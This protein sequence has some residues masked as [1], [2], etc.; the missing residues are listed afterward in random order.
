[1]RRGAKA[2]RDTLRDLV[3]RSPVVEDPV[4]VLV[5]AFVGDSDEQAPAV[6]AKATAG[7]GATNAR[8]PPCPVAPSSRRET[9]KIQL[10]SNFRDGNFGT[11]SRTLARRSMTM[12]M[13]GHDRRAAMLTPPDPADGPADV[14]I[15]TDAGNEIDD[16]FALAWAFLRPDRLRVLA[17]TACPF[18]YDV[19]RELAGA[20][21]AELDKHAH[22][23]GMGTRQISDF[24]KLGPAEGVGRAQDEI[25]RVLEVLGEPAGLA[26]PMGAD[27]YL[28]GPATPVASDA[29]DA[30]IE[31]AR[32]DRQRPLQVLAIGCATNIAS[33]L[34]L[35]PDIADRIVVSWTSAY[36]TF[37]PYP[38][39][40]YNLAQDLHAARVLF[41]S[42]VPLVYLPGYYVGEELRVTLPEID[43]HVAGR[44]PIGDDLAT[45]FRE[46][47]GAAR[48]PGW[49]KVLWDLINVAWVVEPA[50]LAT[51]L[52]TAPI[53]GDDLRWR[54]GG[55]NRH[56]IREATDIDRDSILSDLYARLAE[57]ALAPT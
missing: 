31:L 27:R 38:N 42:G 29:A 44:G 16:Q 46:W 17:V 56:Q 5:D 48:R 34:L 22:A 8:S 43:A 35:A 13:I 47:A 25:V 39:A 21:T 26:V 15:D 10:R 54:T 1:M 2:R 40:S 30:L 18:G 50:W 45:I 41:D 51:N 32:Q 20:G 12:T 9:W 14:V 28:P 11:T 24:P 52:V 57:R 23:L 55:V 33:A 6:N 36:P 37:W 3:S 19:G 49:S 4:D 53:L 7:A